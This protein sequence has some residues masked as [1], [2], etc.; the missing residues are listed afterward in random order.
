[1]EIDERYP[2]PPPLGWARPLAKE[3]GARR[4]YKTKQ[5]FEAALTAWQQ[6]DQSEEREAMRRARKVAL[7]SVARDARRNQEND[8]PN[9][10][11]RRKRQSGLSEGGLAPATASS[12]S[13]RRAEYTAAA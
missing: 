6:E 13:G 11:G 1:M 4:K 2:L 12:A 10:D 9:P 5:E 8:N 7:R 3:V